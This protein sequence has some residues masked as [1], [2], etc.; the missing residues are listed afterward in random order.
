MVRSFERPSVAV[1]Q[2][3][4]RA[5]QP[6]WTAAGQRGEGGPDL[7]RRDNRCST[8]VG[9]DA[10]FSWRPAPTSSAHRPKENPLRAA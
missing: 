7:V 10:R 9:P 6:I 5:S 3:A 8:E 2:A 1:R 4:E